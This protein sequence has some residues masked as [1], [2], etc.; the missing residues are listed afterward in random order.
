MTRTFVGG[1]LIAMCLTHLLWAC[2]V[3]AQG[4][5]QYTIRAGDILKI[6]IWGHD[7]LS[8]EYPVDDDG[9]VPFPLVGRVRASGL[10]TK[11]LAARLTEVLE[12]DYLVNPQVMVVV[13]EYFFNPRNA[14]VMEQPSGVGEVGAIACGDALRLMIKVD[15]ATELITDARFE[16][17]VVSPVPVAL[18]DVPML[19]IH[20]TPNDK[21]DEYRP[22][23]NCCQS[24]AGTSSG[25]C[26]EGIIVALAERRS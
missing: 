6:T 18:I 21:S 20:W 7:D 1:L 15:P 3:Q 2:A 16:T 13:K 11:T 5:Y 22:P 24:T 19:L 9:F 14:G 4:E 10:T 8:K 17:L 23:R 25:G 12:K 26:P